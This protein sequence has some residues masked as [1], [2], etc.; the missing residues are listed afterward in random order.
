M[1][2]VSRQKGKILQNPI[3]VKFFGGENC[4]FWIKKL[5]EYQ[6]REKINVLTL[7]VI[8]HSGLISDNIFL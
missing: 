8:D 4:D 3:S 2:V 1:F 5:F 7:T 6:F